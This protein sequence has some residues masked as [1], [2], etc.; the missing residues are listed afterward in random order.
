MSA[1][2][3]PVL[4]PSAEA[5]RA[6]RRLLSLTFTLGLVVLAVLLPVVQNSDETTQGYRIRALEQQQSDL[7]AKIYAAE[8]DVARLGTLSRINSEARG[9]LGMVPAGQGVSVSINGPAPAFR[10]IPNRYVPPPPAPAPPPVRQ[11]LWERLLRR[12]PLP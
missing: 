1:L 6:L 10:P 9:R 8:A 11:S 3:R 12:L 4:L 2:D 7:Q 5:A